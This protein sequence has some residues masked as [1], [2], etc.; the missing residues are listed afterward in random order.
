MNETILGLLNL[1]KK[2]GQIKLRIQK[3]EERMTTGIGQEK[4]KLIDIG[5]FPINIRI[6]FY[7]GL[8]IDGYFKGS[9]WID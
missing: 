8:D 1:L 2:R 7:K 4:K 5:F 6:G 3:T 9:Y